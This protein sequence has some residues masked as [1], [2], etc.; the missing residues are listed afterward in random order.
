MRLCNM[1]DVNGS[2]H[3]SP[4]GGGDQVSHVDVDF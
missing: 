1:K 4:D 2:A 3:V